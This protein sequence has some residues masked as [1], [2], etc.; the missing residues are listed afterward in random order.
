[1]CVTGD[2][3]ASVLAFIHAPGAGAGW[4]SGTTAPPS[5]NGGSG[6]ASSSPDVISSSPIVLVN[7]NNPAIIHVGDTYND[8]GA[9]ITG[10]QADLN[11]GIKTFVNGTL[12]PEI[13]VD[14]STVATNTIDYVVTDQSGLTATSTR[15]VIIQP[16]NNPAPLVDNAPPP[17][18][19]TTTT[20]I[21]PPLGRYHSVAP[22]SAEFFGIEKQPSRNGRL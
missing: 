17:D 7:G 1:V 18:M 22:V 11:L 15:T 20:A 16:A 14:T 13:T 2:Q 8:L 9:T 4:T 3:L 19:G 6:D 12:M 21:V 10:P 5:S